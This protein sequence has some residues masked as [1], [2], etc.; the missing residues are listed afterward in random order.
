MDE[1]LIAC[2][3]NP[4]LFEAYSLQELYLINEKGNITHCT[5]LNYKFILQPNPNGKG[6]ILNLS[7]RDKKHPKNIIL[8]EE[9]Y[10]KKWACFREELEGR[11][12]C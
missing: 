12:K 3:I 11:K 10:K 9:D 1:L 8:F 7:G 6:S 5:A 2:Y 4:H